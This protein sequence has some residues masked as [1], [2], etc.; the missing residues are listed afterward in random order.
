MLF[1]G[2]VNTKQV[3]GNWT[4]FGKTYLISSES[5]NYLNMAI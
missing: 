5:I 3:M 4:S 1:G 2:K